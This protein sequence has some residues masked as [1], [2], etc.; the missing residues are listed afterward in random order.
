[1]KGAFEPIRPWKILAGW[2]NSL[3]ARLKTMSVA[4]ARLPRARL[5]I[6]KVS[7]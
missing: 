3:T 1:M 6:Q 2:S 7:V 4:A 5:V